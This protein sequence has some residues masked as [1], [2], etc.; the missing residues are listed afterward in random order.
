ML[1][2]SPLGARRASQ[3]SGGGQL[4]S[5]SGFRLQTTQAIE[6]RALA[7]TDNQYH[8][9]Q[10]HGASVPG[11]EGGRGSSIPLLRGSVAVAVVV[12][13]IARKLLGVLLRLRPAD[14]LQ[15]LFVGGVKLFRRDILSQDV[16]EGLNV[17][18]RH[19]L[20]VA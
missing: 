17:A 3:V 9:D 14:P 7:G 15:E 18:V 4:R 5:T 16:D 6:A 13:V 20:E 1:S 10:H 2:C 8:L 19:E 11:P 12:F